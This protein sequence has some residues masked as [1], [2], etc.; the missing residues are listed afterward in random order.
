MLRNEWDAWLYICT[1]PRRPSSQPFLP[2]KPSIANRSQNEDCFT[3][4]P[5]LNLLMLQRLLFNICHHIQLFVM[6]V[7]FG[8]V[9]TTYMS[10]RTSR[11]PSFVWPEIISW[12]VGWKGRYILNRTG[13]VLRKWF[14]SILHLITNSK[15]SGR[16]AK[17][18]FYGPPNDAL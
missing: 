15:S 4:S 18:G 12:N 16:M 7:L 10:S 11:H 5:T 17:N 1:R 8:A 6:D 14:C 9:I 13:S 3:T 2:S